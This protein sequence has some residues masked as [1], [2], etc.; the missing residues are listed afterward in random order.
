MYLFFKHPVSRFRFFF[1]SCLV[2]SCFILKIT[3]F[4][5]SFQ[6]SCPSYPVKC[7]IVFPDSQSV[8]TCFPWSLMCSNSLRLPV[9]CASMLCPVPTCITR[10]LIPFLI[11]IVLPRACSRA[12]LLQSVI[13]CK[14]FI[15]IVYLFMHGKFHS[16]VLFRCLW[17]VLIWNHF[18]ATS[19]SGEFVFCFRNVVRDR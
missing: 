4:P 7:L 8:S 18:I 12:T 10:I 11:A 14:L 6:V 9:S 2:I 3:N 1:M 16:F 17:R 13:L 19:V 15:A 5:L